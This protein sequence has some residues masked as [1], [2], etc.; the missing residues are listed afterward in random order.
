MTS[1]TY[2]TTYH[3]I[4]H[5]FVFV[6]LSLAHTVCTYRTPYTYGR[7]PEVICS[8]TL[9]KP[10]GWQLLLQSLLEPLVLEPDFYLSQISSF[11]Q[12][13]IL[14]NFLLRA[15]QKMGFIADL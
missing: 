15:F 9:L 1:V 12:L 11:V 10:L 5:L 14:N 3:Y 6:Y 7:L 2:L 4:S 13:C 8:V